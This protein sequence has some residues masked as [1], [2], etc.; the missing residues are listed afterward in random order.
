MNSWKVMGVLLAICLMVGSLSAGAASVKNKKTLDDN[1][2][3]DVY[4]KI[5]GLNHGDKVVIYGGKVPEN[6]S[7]E[8]L[9]NSFKLTVERNGIIRLPISKEGTW[10][11]SAGAS[12]Y[13]EIPER[14][15]IEV[16]KGDSITAE[17]KLGMA[18]P[19]LKEKASSGMAEIGT[20]VAL[21]GTVLE[22]TDKTTEMMNGTH[23]L[24]GLDDKNHYMLKGDAFDLKTYEGEKVWIE[25][26]LINTGDNERL[27]LL[28]IK[29][30]EKPNNPTWIID[31][32]GHVLSAEE[33]STNQLP[34]VDSSVTTARE[35]EENRVELAPVN[36]QLIE[37]IS[38]GPKKLVVLEQ[39]VNGNVDVIGTSDGSE[40]FWNSDLMYDYT[41]SPI[42][43]AVT[44]LFY[45]NAEV[46]KIKDDIY[47]GP[48]PLHYIRYVRLSDDS[49]TGG[50]WE[51]DQDK[52]T[53]E[54]GIAAK[55]MRLFAPYPEDKFYDTDLGFF[56]VGTT[57][58]DYSSNTEEDAENAMC[59]IAIDKGYTVYEDYNWFDTDDFG[60]NNGYASFV[61]IP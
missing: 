45:D 55:H 29:D 58:W 1:G 56:V 26:V 34:E 23:V 9:Q 41:G 31:A 53:R 50:N 5:K 46:D 48:A 14:Y 11:V 40:K 61:E 32:Q 59:D 42:D 2:T 10:D 44:M 6:E 38:G 57:H 51:F 35:S 37:A 3:I 15:L 13:G 47:W 21:I 4:A 30:I 36:M 8:F 16:Q 12:E 7:Q 54:T 17:F 49:Y 43:H 18:L 28:K 25:G 22:P 52:G 24:K 60:S 20:N 33:K 27:P 39:G 19:T